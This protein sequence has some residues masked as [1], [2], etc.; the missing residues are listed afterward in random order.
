MCWGFGQ[1]DSAGLLD[2]S[3]S[4]QKVAAERRQPACALGIGDT[5]AAFEQVEDSDF[6]LAVVCL[7][8]EAPRGQQEHSL[9][10]PWAVRS[11]VVNRFEGQDPGNWV[12]VR[13]LGDV[14]QIKVAALG[15][16]VMVF[17]L[18]V[19]IAAESA[20]QHASAASARRVR[21]MGGHLAADVAYSG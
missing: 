13:C 11:F 18:A 20:S 4:G 2:R 16:I 9:A 21:E 19:D 3:G 6:E 7:R 17:E 15:Q 1:A 5:F 12:P 10:Q 14:A 8:A